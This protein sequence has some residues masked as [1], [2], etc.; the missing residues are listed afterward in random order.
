[1]FVRRDTFEQVGLCPFDV[2]KPVNLRQLHVT[3]RRQR[4]AQQQS[5]LLTFRLEK[6]VNGDIARNLMRRHTRAEAQRHGGDCC[7]ERA[8]SGHAAQCILPRVCRPGL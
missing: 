3:H 5:K 7:D 8:A 6:R 2:E 1:M 4:H